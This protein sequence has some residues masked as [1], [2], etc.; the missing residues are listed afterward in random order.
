MA[1]GGAVAGLTVATDVTDVD[2]DLSAT[3]RVELVS[4]RVERFK[5]R[6]GTESDVFFA[7]PPG[8]AVVDVNGASSA[9][10][11]TGGAL[12]ANAYGVW[13]AMV[14]LGD[15]KD[16]A[17]LAGEFT[18]E[19]TNEPDAPT[20]DA[21]SANLSVTIAE[22]DADQTVIDNA[23]LA[24]NV[25]D[26]DYA[27]EGAV[28]ASLTATLTGRDGDDDFAALAERL[29]VTSPRVVLTDD[30]GGVS[31]TLHSGV[32][33]ADAYGAWTATLALEDGGAG[34]YTVGGI[35]VSVTPDPDAPTAG[36]AA[37][38]TPVT[39]DEPDADLPYTD[40]AVLATN[41]VDV[42]YATD[43]AV[44]ASLTATLAVSDENAALAARLFTTSPRVALS[45][46][47]S[48]LSVTLEDYTVRANANGDWTATLR[49]IDGAEPP[50]SIG[51]FMVQVAPL[52]D[53]LLYTSDAAD[54]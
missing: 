5:E 38:S 35:T 52:P 15:G 10:V 17:P 12:A 26:A 13:A 46:D 14:A 37:D 24:T 21:V 29:F 50:V 43:A 48:G 11:L 39:L 44:L 28:L 30:G 4:A 47:G 36:F 33:V 9:V 41:V 40:N 25:A 22:P 2:D 45:D 23:V 19:V 20:A 51:E 18:L 1:E 53:C 32:P 8:V 27:T 6:A 54:E 31:V 49:L 42:D 16:A 3:V 34:R 7:T